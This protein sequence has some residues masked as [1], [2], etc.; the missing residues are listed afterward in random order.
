M[1]DLKRYSP[2]RFT[3]KNSSVLPNHFEIRGIDVSSS[4]EDGDN[5]A[6]FFALCKANW[7]V[8][9]LMYNCGFIH[10]Y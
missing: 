9:K 2:A 6:A 10:E 4:V 3:L 7:L 1:W 5:E 8:Y